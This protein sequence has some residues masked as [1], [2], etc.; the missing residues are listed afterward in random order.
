MSRGQ[1]NKGLTP[2]LLQQM[3]KQILPPFHVL[4]AGEL[5]SVPVFT[6]FVGNFIETAKIN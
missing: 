2:K 6:F 1:F 3:Q 5:K 4:N